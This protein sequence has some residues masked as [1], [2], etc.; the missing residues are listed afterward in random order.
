MG[1]DMRVGFTPRGKISFQPSEF[2]LLVLLT[3]FNESQGIEVIVA[4]WCRPDQLV[5]IV[6]PLP[7]LRVNLQGSCH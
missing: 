2:A 6:R 1:M 5:P 3:F 4:L 7:G